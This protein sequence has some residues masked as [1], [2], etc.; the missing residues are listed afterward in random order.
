MNH[1]YNPVEAQCMGKQAF[2]S[3]SLATQ[4]ARKGSRS[5]DVPVSSYKCE[6]CGAYHVGQSSLKRTQAG[7][8]NGMKYLEKHA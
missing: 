5:K 4:V 2:A 3:R 1:Q 7:V 6:H 8:G